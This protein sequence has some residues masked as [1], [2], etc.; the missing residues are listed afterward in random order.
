[1]SEY[2]L[3]RNPM[4]LEPHFIK[5]MSAM[6]REGLHNKSDI[7]CELAYRDKEIER[8]QAELTRL[9]EQKPVA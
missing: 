3:D 2:N 1:M 5:H 4:E 8:L 9:H 7:A 6:T